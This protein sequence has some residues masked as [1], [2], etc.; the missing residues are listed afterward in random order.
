MQ[1]DDFQWNKNM[2]LQLARSLLPNLSDEDIETFASIFDSSN[3]IM[4]DI[5]VYVELVFSNNQ[6]KE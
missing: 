3:D 5:D 6:Y 2:M 1:V 4:K